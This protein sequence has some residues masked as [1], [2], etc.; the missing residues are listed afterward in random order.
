[1]QRLPDSNPHPPSFEEAIWF[2]RK[3]NLF[4]KTE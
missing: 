2:Y 3:R 4:K 1:M